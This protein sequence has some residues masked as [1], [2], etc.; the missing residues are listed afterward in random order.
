MT[1]HFQ[2]HQPETLPERFSSTKPIPKSIAI[3][4]IAQGSLV[5]RTILRSEES[6]E[7]LI[8]EWMTKTSRLLRH[9]GFEGQELSAAINGLF[10]DALTF[11]DKKDLARFAGKWKRLHPSPN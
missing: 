2:P 6:F 10:Q 11:F 8:Q 3:P 4:A 7:T 9:E 5:C 1:V